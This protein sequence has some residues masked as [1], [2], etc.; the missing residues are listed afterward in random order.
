M[1]GFG[2]TNN[3]AMFHLSRLQLLALRAAPRTASCHEERMTGEN[4]HI[5]IFD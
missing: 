4:K 5:L 1:R 2:E 3:F